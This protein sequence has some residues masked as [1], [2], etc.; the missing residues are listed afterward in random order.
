MTEKF[1]FDDDAPVQKKVRQEGSLSGSDHM[2]KQET[3]KDT[4]QTRRKVIQEHFDPVSGTRTFWNMRGDIISKNVEVVRI[5]NHLSNNSKEVETYSKL[6]S[7]VNIQFREQ[8]CTIS[9]SSAYLYVPEIVE[10]FLKVNKYK[11]ENYQELM[12]DLHNN[13]PKEP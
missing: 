9:L 6:I 13:S 3:K 11:L 8:L 2:Y 4:S 10:K 1:E 5:Q 12:D 7:V